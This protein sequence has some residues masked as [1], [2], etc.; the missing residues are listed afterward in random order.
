MRLIVVIAC[1]FKSDC[2]EV[3]RACFPSC[4]PHK[5]RQSEIKSV[6]ALEKVIQQLTN[7]CR[8]I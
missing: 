4:E 2:Q 7:A 6:G 8:R 3:P 5:I 1:V